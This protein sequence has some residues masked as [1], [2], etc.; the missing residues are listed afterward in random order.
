MG[1]EANHRYLVDRN[2]IDRMVARGWMVEGVVF[3]APP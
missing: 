2:E 1:G 3:C